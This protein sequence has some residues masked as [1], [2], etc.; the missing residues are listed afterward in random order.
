MTDSGSQK[1]MVT[2][3]E[4]RWAN[5]ASLRVFN[6]P[7]AAT[8]SDFD[9]VG[10]PLGEETLASLIALGREIEA[11]DALRATASDASPVQRTRKEQFKK[12]SA[13]GFAF[14]IVGGF[15]VELPGN[16]T[17][18]WQ[19]G[20]QYV[21][22]HSTAFLLGGLFAFAAFVFRVSVDGEPWWS[23]LIGVFV[24]TPIAVG[25]L[26]LVLAVVAKWLS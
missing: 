13:I 20:Q 23:A 17:R 16:I 15:L 18:L 10:A 19:N 2:G 25:M 24:V 12:W 1:R 21:R 8:I 4:A 5:L 6:K 14:E 22:T 26:I 3:D 7:L 9:K 11:A